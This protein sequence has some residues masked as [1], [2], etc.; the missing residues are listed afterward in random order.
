MAERGAEKL[1][2]VKNLGLLLSSS[3]ENALYVGRDVTDVASIKLYSC[4]RRF[5]HILQCYRARTEFQ[6]H[7]RFKTFHK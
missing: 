5:S 7:K 6:N 1:N 2:I 4:Q 3:L